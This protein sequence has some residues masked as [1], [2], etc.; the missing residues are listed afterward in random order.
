MIYDKLRRLESQDTPIRLSVSGADWLGS[1][2][3]RQLAHVPGMRVNVVADVDVEAAH[4]ALRVCGIP[5]DAIV[6]AQS[7]GLASDALRAGKRVV[8]GD[9]G[10]AAQLDEID[11]VTDAT[12][13]PAVGA[14][15]AYAAIQGGKH[16]VMV[17]I[18]ADVTVGRILKKL[19]QDAGVLYTVSSGDEPGCLMELYDF[20][21]TL[22]MEPIV[23]GKG[24]NN[25]LD[26]S[27]TPDM[28][29]ES[30]LKADKDPFQV[31][32]Y[33]DGT[34]TM[35][36]MA[37]AA[38]ATGCLPM[39]R[40]M[41]GPTITQS[42][43]GDRSLKAVL[44]TV[45]RTFAL[46]ADGGITPRP[47]TVDFVQGDVL[48]GGVFITVRVQDE[49]IRD[50]LQYLKVGKG[51]YFTFYRHYHLWF[52][53]A[54]ISVAKAYLNREQWLV[55]LDHPVAEVMAVAKRDLRPGDTLDEFGGYT[56]YGV[57]DRVEG[58]D[59]VNALPVGI[60]PG[61]R[62][63]K[64]VAQGQTVTWDAVELDESST[65]VKLRRIQDEMQN[66]EQGMKEQE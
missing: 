54:P 42:E 53:E 2:F 27:A 28:V 7:P 52:I 16:V 29:R 14:E 48:A 63:I 44:E 60:A 4:A 17:N 26:P 37:C 47:G 11:I 33:V 24:K 59:Q 55:P 50:D 18:E 31:A 25:P 40:G 45:S 1:G 61:A 6:E 8:T 41:V 57:M 51:E 3:V 49:R 30:A 62:V 64:P 32:S 10:L 38:N 13:S 9:Y 65:V 15:T 46:Q 34:K 21:C 39:R 22:G 35:F 66:T 23:I 43:D 58:A 36:E 5:A 19:A 20:C 12:P 56:F